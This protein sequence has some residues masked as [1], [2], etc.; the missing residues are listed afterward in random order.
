MAHHHHHRSLFH[1][2][3]RQVEHSSNPKRVLKGTAKQLVYANRIIGAVGSAVGGYFG[4][5][6]V[7]GLFGAGSAETGYYL[8]GIQAR[9]EGYHGKAAHH[10]QRSERSRDLKIDLAAAG[11]GA[12]GSAVTTALAG[13]SFGQ[14]AAAFGGGQVGGNLIAG[15]TGP[16]LPGVIGGSGPINAAP[17]VTGAAAQSSG[18]FVTTASLAA[19]SDSGAGLGGG[20]VSSYSQLGLTPAAS[21]GGFLSGSTGTI[22][23]VGGAA[24]ASVPSILKLLAGSGTKTTAEG[25]GPNLGAAGGSGDSGSSDPGQML[26]GIAGGLLD[27]FKEHPILA[28][29]AGA[30]IAYALT[31]GKA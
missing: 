4:G 28:L 7:G 30:L 21:G 22:A 29:S 3:A 12:A 2:I 23:A 31:K 15:G 25:S 8:R 20:V 13:G 27:F 14:T 26:S 11:G 16:G 5:P 18:G 19:P 10:F 1:R 17:A 6:I 24:L 9:H